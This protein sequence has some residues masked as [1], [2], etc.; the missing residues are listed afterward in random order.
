MI[1]TMRTLVPLFTDLPTHPPSGYSLYAAH[2]H[3]NTLTFSY[4]QAQVS[5]MH[6]HRHK[7]RHTDTCLDWSC[8]FKRQLSVQLIKHFVLPSYPYSFYF[9]AYFGHFFS[10]RLFTRMQV[11]LFLF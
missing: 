6:Q 8:H 11:F 1:M 4:I 10:V 5:Y 9:L 2:S 7:L 3:S